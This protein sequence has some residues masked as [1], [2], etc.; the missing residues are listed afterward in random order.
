[1]LFKVYIPFKHR[2]FLKKKYLNKYLKKYLNKYLTAHLEEQRSSE[3]WKVIGYDIGSHIQ[4]L[5]KPYYND[6]SEM[7]THDEFTW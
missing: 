6:L 1:M 4:P 5:D 2:N 3:S 7:L